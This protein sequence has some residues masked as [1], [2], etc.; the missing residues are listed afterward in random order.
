MVHK[1]STQY[2]YRITTDSHATTVRSEFDLDK[3][4]TPGN[5]FGYDIKINNTR[6]KAIKKFLHYVL[7]AENF[8]L[9]TLKLFGHTCLVKIQ[10]GHQKLIFYP[11]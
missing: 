8:C 3:K 2:G 4:C 6:W 10:N 7:K 5:H 1:T 9:H 11:I